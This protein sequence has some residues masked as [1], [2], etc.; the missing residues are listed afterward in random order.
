MYVQ[1]QSRRYQQEYDATVTALCR[2]SGQIVLLA[3]KTCLSVL[4]TLVLGA[5]RNTIWNHVPASSA[6]A[7]TESRQRHSEIQQNQ[8]LIGQINTHPP[9]RASPPS[10]S[11]ARG[12]WSHGKRDRR[13]SQEGGAGGG[14]REG[15]VR[16]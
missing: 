8:P 4:K 16:E 9:A 1:K 12:H 11:P 15:E 7:A 3:K 14:E 2:T 13:N 6:P 10:R 5:S